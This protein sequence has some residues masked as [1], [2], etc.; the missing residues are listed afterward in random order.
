VFH[1]HVHVL[2]RHANDGVAL[3]WPRKD[4]PADVLQGHAEKIRAALASMA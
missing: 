1:F 3:S 2:P 4:P